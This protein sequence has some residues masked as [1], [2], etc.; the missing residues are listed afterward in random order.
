M[1]S[2]VYDRCAVRSAIID[3]NMNTAIL[4]VYDGKYYKIPGGGI[5]E[6]ESEMEA[7]HREMK[8]EAGCQIE[9]IAKIGESAIFDPDKNKVFH[10]SCYLSRLSGKK[11]EPEFDEDEISRNYKLLWVNLGEAIELMEQ[12]VVENDRHNR[13]HNRDLEF[14]KKAKEYMDK[15]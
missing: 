5:E 6:G 7:L 2:N 1:K 9:V 15:L 13:I 11:G 3:A 10:S 8:E 4:S 12:T 14:L